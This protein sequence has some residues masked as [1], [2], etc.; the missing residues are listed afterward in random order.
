MATEV[1]TYQHDPQTQIEGSWLVDEEV[2][3]RRNVEIE[4]YGAFIHEHLATGDYDDADS[5]VEDSDVLYDDMHLFFSAIGETELI[6]HFKRNKVTLA[7]L[8]E[9][10]EQDLINCGIE[11]VG[12][13][14]KIMSHLGQM[15]CDEWLPTSLHDLTQKSMMTG[16]G[17][18]IS[19]NAI[20]KHLEFIGVTFRYVTRK[21]QLSPEILELGKDYV[22][23]KKVASELEDVGKTCANLKNSLD[24]LTREIAKHVDSPVLEPAHHID[25]K[26]VRSVKLQNRLYPTIMVTIAAFTAYK[27]IRYFTG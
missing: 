6:E 19:I 5:D 21:L 23:V 9:F 1:A 24:R 13:R 7:Q 18:Y 15:H 2:E 8:L 4:N 11:L 26:S 3:E 16:P 20:N 22:G 10:D 27:V 14:K 12:D 25:A 17:L